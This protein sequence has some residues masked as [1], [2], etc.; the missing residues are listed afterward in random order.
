MATQLNKSMV[1]EL[2]I[3]NQALGYLGANPIVSFD[4]P[5]TSA[6]LMRD[7][8]PFIRDAVMTEVAWTFAVVR[9]TSTTADRDAW[10]QKFVHPG[11]RTHS[12][13][14]GH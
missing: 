6:E 2:S 12:V 7:N 9:A 14:V 10:D 11:N 13:Y 1:S 3:A 4:E 8:Y 5:S